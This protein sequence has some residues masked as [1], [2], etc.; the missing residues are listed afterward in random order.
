MNSFCALV[1]CSAVCDACRIGGGFIGGNLACET[2]LTLENLF[3]FAGGLFLFPVSWIW[4]NLC[5]G[6]VLSGWQDSKS[7][8]WLLWKGEPQRAK[9]GLQEEKDDK[10]HAPVQA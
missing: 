3:L 8:S 2:Q 1:L 9:G 7:R 10:L 5:D 6:P 4:G